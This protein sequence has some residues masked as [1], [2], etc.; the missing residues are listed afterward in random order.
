MSALPCFRHP[1]CPPG[2][3]PR[4]GHTL[5]E[6]L[7]VLVLIGVLLSAVL[8]GWTEYLARRRVEAAS[9]QLQADLAELRHTAVARDTG[10]RMTFRHSAEGSCYLMHNGDAALCDCQPDGQGELIPR[11]T[12]GAHLLLARVWRADDL[13]LRANITSLRADPRQGGVSPS[14]SIELRAAGLQPLRHVV[15][16]LGRVRLCSVVSDP[17]LPGW[18]GL[19]TC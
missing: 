3:S 15:N 8:P 7:V 17:T 18:R 9:S 14:G 4:N 12:D 19:S 6:A 16:L 2:L 10:L 13:V 5:L 1:T 11:C